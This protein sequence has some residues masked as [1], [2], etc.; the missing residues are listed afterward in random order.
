MSLLRRTKAA[1]RAFTASYDATSTGRRSRSWGGVNGGPNA[2]AASLP[3]LRN[4]SRDAV[5][6]DPLADAAIDVA[7]TNVIGTGIKPQ[8]ATSD[9]GLNK[10][11]AALW[12]D[13]TDEAD[14]AG[15]LDFYGLQA[16]AVRSMIEGGDAFGRF[17]L[18]RPEDGLDVPLQIQVLEGEFCPAE[19]SEMNGANSIISGV[20]FTPFG[21]RTAYW[22]YREHPYDGT[23]PRMQ[24]GLPVRVPASE[25]FHLMQ[26]RRPGQVRGEPWLT[27][28]LVKLNELAQYDDAEL[29]R[30][31]IAAMFVGFRRRPVPE[32]MTPEDL[33][34]AWGGGAEIEDGI[35]HVSL[36]PGTMQDLEPGEDVEFTA[37]VDVGGNYEVFL[38]A[39]RRLVASAAGVLY[40]QLTGDYSQVNDRTFRASVNEFRRRCQAWQHHLAVFQMCRPTHRQWMAAAV[41]SGA[42]RP[43]RSMTERDLLRV[44]W[45][46]Q[47][48]S[49]IHPVQDVQSQ[50]MAVRNGFKSRAEVVSEQGY[51]AEQ[52]DAEQAAD[53]ARADAVGLSYDSDGRRAVSDPTKTTETEG[54]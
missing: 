5:R 13:W 7:V 22:F 2:P 21:S 19:K 10:D 17:R 6:N 36:E 54:V 38:R 45:V 34:E 33:A 12:L 28:A 25:V 24:A 49:Y 1:W 43:P 20:E 9:A 48:W 35:G 15:Q 46:P 18:R 44:K 51:D 23:N 47:G 31:Q 4:R 8:F 16:L 41:L 30:K 27:R 52:I 50:Q 39:Q 40:E 14:P 3:T 29:K 53:N 37:P 32:G 11:L 26:V 42:V